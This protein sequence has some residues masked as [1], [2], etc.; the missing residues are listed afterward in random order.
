MSLLTFRDIPK[1]AEKSFKASL[2]VPLNLIH[3][4]NPIPTVFLPMLAGL[5]TPEP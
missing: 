1:L 3:F 5:E 4:I 2:I